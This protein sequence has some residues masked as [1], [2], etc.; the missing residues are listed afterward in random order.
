MKNEVYK[1]NLDTPDELL[2]HNMDAVASMK[3][4]ED[5]LRRINT[6]FVDELQSAMRFTVGF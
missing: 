1:I 6:V 3:K 5:Q 2:A 4:R